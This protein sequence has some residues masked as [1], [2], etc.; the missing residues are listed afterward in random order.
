MS[1]EFPI[2][3][4]R[5]RQYFLAQ[6]QALQDMPFMSTWHFLPSVQAATATLVAFWLSPFCAAAWDKSCWRA[7]PKQEKS[8]E[9]GTS[10]PSKIG[11]VRVAIPRYCPAEQKSANQGASV[12]TTF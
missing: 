7:W 5:S 12:L 4:S 6:L 1:P 9:F 11:M 3:L 2:C 10:Q 8:N